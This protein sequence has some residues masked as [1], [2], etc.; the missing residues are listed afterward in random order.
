MYF[1]RTYLSDVCLPHLDQL[2]A[3]ALFGLLCS[4][5]VSLKHHLKYEA[6]QLFWT[7]NDWCFG[8][9]RVLSHFV[10]LQCVPSSLVIL[11]LKLCRELHKVLAVSA[12]EPLLRQSSAEVHATLSA[13]S[14]ESSASQPSCGA[15]R[16]AAQISPRRELLGAPPPVLSAAQTGQ[17]PFH[18]FDCF[19]LQGLGV[20]FPFRQVESETKYPG[21]KHSVQMHGPLGLNTTMFA[22]SASKNSVV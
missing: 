18:D 19:L 22:K 9:Y 11:L 6:P 12:A 8:S 14:P 21:L 2:T 7:A 4:L 20:I 5:H 16:S 3:H 10:Y 15:T 13:A 17:P 1:W